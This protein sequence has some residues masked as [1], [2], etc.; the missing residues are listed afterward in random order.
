MPWKQNGAEPLRIKYFVKTYPE[1]LLEDLSAAL[2]QCSYRKGSFI[3]YYSAAEWVTSQLDVVLTVNIA[4]PIL[5][6][7]LP[8]LVEPLVD[9]PGLEDEL[10][11][12]PRAKNKRPAADDLISP[13]KKMSR[14]NHQDS[15]SI[16]SQSR[17]KDTTL[18][19]CSTADVPPLSTCTSKSL[20]AVPSQRSSIPSKSLAPFPL[21]LETTVKPEAKA[22][23]R[24]F[25]VSEVVDG[26]QSVAVKMNGHITQ[27]LAFTQV[28]PGVKYN[29]G[30]ISK[31]RMVLERV[32]SKL[33]QHFVDFGKTPKG[34]WTNF[35]DSLPSTILDKGFSRTDSTVIADL[36]KKI[37]NDNA[38]ANDSDSTD[39]LSLGGDND[40]SGLGSP[41]PDWDYPD[42]RCAFCD[43]IIPADFKPSA[44]LEKMRKDL[45]PLSQPDP[46]R[47]FNPNHRKTT[48]A[49][50]YM[51]HCQRHQLELELWPAARQQGWPTE[52]KFS[53]LH[54]RIVMLRPHLTDL[55][56]TANLNTNEF[57]LDYQNSFAPGTSRAGAA[58]VSGLWKSF[59]G[60]G[61]G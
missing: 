60:H 21:D 29:K 24:D 8:S 47:Y 7:L 59:K 14:H 1:L 22:W 34:K 57:Y 16:S 5:I 20:L 11:M 52:I 43:E 15:D 19:R 23:P 50:V 10:K 36:E 13:P 61:T 30:Q 44:T 49:L 6:R 53:T 12:Q 32:G 2:E 54:N 26:L 55:L 39:R 9:C 33:E 51:E 27:A 3:Q 31:V 4:Y 56:L 18:R 35:R 45:Q 28:F 38:S 17:D 46:I 41:D 42:Q 48:S 37:L 25:Y 58:G 40:D